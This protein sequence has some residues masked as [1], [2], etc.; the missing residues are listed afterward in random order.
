MKRRTPRTAEDPKASEPKTWSTGT[1]AVVSSLRHIVRRAGVGRGGKALLKVNQHDGFDCPSCAWPDPDGRRATAEFCEN[2]AK[3]VAS[4]AMTKSIGGAFFA[5]RSLEDLRA[6]SDAWH[7]LQGRLAEPLL[8][9]DGQHYRP[10]GW[11]DA[12]ALVGDALRGLE[13]PHQAVFYT[14]GR[15]SNEAAFLYGVFARAYGTN[16][17]P[18]CSNMCHESSG[19]ALSASIGVGKGTVS[20]ADLEAADVILCAGQN[21]GTNHPRMLSTLEAAVDAG[22]H[23]VAINPLK[24]AGLMAFAHPQ[25][26]LGLL[27]RATK[28][29]ETYLQVRV[30]G[31]M[32]LFRGFA[33]ALFEGDA[34]DHAFVAKHTTG[35]EAYRAAVDATEWSTIESLSGI[36]RSAIEAVAAR[37]ADTRKIITCWAMGLTQHHNAVATIREVANLHLLRGAIGVEGGGLCPVRG[38]SNV[39]GDRTVGICEKMPE[40]FYAGIDEHVFAGKATCP[41][42]PGW[43]TV[44]AIR[45]MHRGDVKVFV[46]LGGNFLMASP[47]TQFVAD[48]MKK[49]ELIVQISTKLNRGHLV[50]GKRALILPCLGRTEDDAGRFVSC[51]N[52]MGIVQSSRGRLTPVSAQLKSEPEIIAGIAAA[53]LGEDL[54]KWTWLVEDYDRVRDLIEK[55]VPGF[56]SYNERVRVDGGFYLPNPAKER[57]WHTPSRKASFS[58]ETLSAFRARPGH[59]V[60]QTIRSHD[61]F[62]TTIYGL[63]DRYRGIRGGR[64]VVFL[65]KEDMDELGVS[66]MQRV[67]LTSHYEGVERHAADFA[68]IPYDMPRGHAAAYFPEAN[69]LVPIDSVAA[70]SNTPTSKSIEISIRV[71]A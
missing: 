15:A 62:N 16:N 52:S 44:D 12:F 57:R 3:A 19:A 43:D 25:K 4:E 47:D 50:V 54:V 30:N 69:A 40:S 59:F 9:D 10:I 64:R 45:A 7:D 5:S 53:A 24:E 65:A 36:E 70:V 37:L 8:V 11:D 48:A 38:H 29:A 60:L 17:L 34:V 61:Q 26:A 33:K 46:A 22:A 18:D 35:F 66:A 56:E 55:V 58:A 63:D 39:Q 32:A 20:I 41:R 23:M 71:R 42:E 14:S 68:A 31:D 49:V 6:Q 1:P 2:G 28:L 13:S 67:D 21:P 27:G 51:E